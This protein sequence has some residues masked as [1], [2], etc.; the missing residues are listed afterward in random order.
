MV[1]AAHAVAELT[2]LQRHKEWG[3]G[4]IVILGVP[5][6]ESL[7]SWH[8]RL[9]EIA[10]SDH[11][12]FEEPYYDNEMTALAVVCPDGQLREIF[13]DLELCKL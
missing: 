5:D 6:L 9:S 13:S 8:N 12:W 11:A 3:N 1:Q 7:H 10:E 2:L 4:T